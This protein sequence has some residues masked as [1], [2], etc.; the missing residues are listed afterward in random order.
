ML[1]TYF[2]IA[3]R[4]LKKN[5]GYTVI[6]IAGLA[7]GMAIALL[8]GLWIADE[9]S[10]EHY[11]TN[12]RRIAQNLILRH[13]PDGVGVWYSSAVPMEK[14]LR[15]K[16]ANLFEKTALVYGGDEHLVSVGDKKISA[17]GLWAEK[18]FPEIFTF[19][20]LSGSIASM[21]D[22]STALIS[23]SLATSL[24]GQNDPVGKTFRYENKLDLTIGGVF[25]DLPKNTSYFGT[26]MVLPWDNKENGYHNTNTSWDDHNAQLYVLLADKVTAEQAT[27]RIRNLPTPH[28]KG[29]REE[30][31]LYPLDDF[32]LYGD[33]KDGKPV[34]GGIRYVWMFGLIGGFVLLLA[35]INFMNLSTARSER[36]AK[37][38]GI[39][40][41]AGSLKSQLVTQFLSESVLVA[42]LSFV[43]SLGLVEA[44]LPFFNSLSAKDMALPWNQWLFWLLA[45]G[46]T[47]FTGLLAGSYPAFYLSGFNP[48]RVL[49]GTFRV[50]RY[51]GL[52]RQILVVIQFS[53]SLTL[54]IGTIIVYRQIQFTKDRPLG[55]KQDRLVSV[56][57]NTPEL[58]AHYPALRTELLQQRLVEDI[59]GSSMKVTGFSWRNEVSWR[60]KRPDQAAIL[61]N[62]VNVTPEFGRTIGWQV[63]QGRDFDRAYSTDSTAIVINEAAAAVI[64]FRNP[65]GETL[66][67]DNRNWTVI[68]VVKNMVVNSPY[69]KV[70]P[71]IFLGDGWG[72]SITLR[73]PAGKPAHA[74]LGAIASVFSKYNP[75][76]PFLYQFMNEEYNKK[77]ADETR[78]GNL[79]GVFA[80][81]A[82]FISCLGLF[83]L[84]SFVAEQRT[85]EI[86]VRK[87]LGARVLALW[88]LQSKGFLKLVV[89][90]FLISMPLGYWIMNK[91]LQNYTYHTALSW[92]IFALAGSGILLITLLTVSY[93]S[94]KAAMMNPVK[95]L[96]SE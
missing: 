71:A 20:M 45:I 36:R 19:K 34:A 89:L 83:G 51:A 42:L 66:K 43:L 70:D 26:K 77:F 40:K 27:A 93:Q 22:P 33:F 25:E 8:I 74:A 23:A 57:I 64:G 32:L 35:C 29:W 21:T 12:Y 75:G 65:I 88:S 54:I 62:N 41:T 37:E 94:L 31:M 82:I 14:E 76:S 92:W 63:L 68:G 38:V 50:G 28:I 84:A 4:H 73:L 10:F 69:D 67:Y 80:G 85:K 2:R 90:S 24:F 56:D 72:T 44:A 9:F 91:W 46:F 1:S 17:A 48:V 11:H 5:K 16:Y 87:V 81:L 49:K 60:G 58:R 18:E 47:F 53:V 3:W 78:I 13:T 61:F 30:A 59:A 15:D 7:T 95:S 6:N 79:A 39:R 96:R 55:Y 86:G 52:P